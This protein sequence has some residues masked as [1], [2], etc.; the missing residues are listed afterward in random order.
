MSVCV[1]KVCRNYKGRSKTT[2]N[3]TYHRI[4][5]DPIMRSRWTQ[6]IQRS[7]CEELWKPSKYSLVCSDHFNKNEMYFVN[8]E[9]RRRLKKQ[10]FH[11]LFLSS[12]QSDGSD[13]VTDEEIN[14]SSIAFDAGSGISRDKPHINFVDMRNTSNAPENT[15]HWQHTKNTSN[16]TEIETEVYE[17]FSDLDS[18]FDTPKEAKLRR[19]LH[20]K[21]ILQRK[22]ILKIQSLRRK[23]IRLKKKITTYKEI[24]GN[25]KK[26]K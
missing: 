5:S 15:G 21:N 3:V 6:I 9:G 26:E 23:I 20:R 2:H 13:I 4:P 12:V 8:N 18:V 14:N 11:A 10:R 19:D 7:R 16:D 1:F 25:L 24:I 17:E 22:H